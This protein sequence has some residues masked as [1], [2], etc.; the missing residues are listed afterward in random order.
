MKTKEQMRA[1]YEHRSQVLELGLRRDA[2]I[3]IAIALQEGGRIGLA[4]DI[5]DFLESTNEEAGK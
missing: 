3:S 1:E 2:W 5:R 4:K